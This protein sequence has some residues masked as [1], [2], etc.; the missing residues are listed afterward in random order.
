MGMRSELGEAPEVVRSLIEKQ[1]GVI[2]SV[3][4]AIHSRPVDMV[5]I[6]ARGTSD[7]AATYAQYVFGVYNKLPVALAAPSIQSLYGVVPRLHNALVIG[8]S[9]SGQSPDVVGVIEEARRQKA[10]TIAVTNDTGSPLSRAAEFHID[11]HAGP[12]L[13]VAATKTYVAELAALA[14]LSTALNDQALA[15]QQLGEVADAIAAAVGLE[16]A[17]ESAA[18]EQAGI[19]RAVVLG[20]GFNYSTAL[21]WSLK[22]KEMTYVL[23]DAYSTADFEHGPIAMI[24]P[25]FVVHAVAADG[26]T[27]PEIKMVLGRLRE[28][29]ARLVVASN[30]ADALAFA[31][32]PLRLPATPEWLS[33]LSAII[34][35]QLF[36]YHLALAKH[37]DTDHPRGIQKVTRTR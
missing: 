26:P 6:A 17:V 16:D 9:Q 13:A 33:P 37:L 2:D 1:R 20:R 28:A 35:G 31:D 7:H 5:L 36:A 11:I 30:S 18:R 34:P 10:P 8:I 19:R 27:L 24:D 25:G 29:G 4:E 14:M 3:A 23:A 22:L 12:E 15:R 32:V 21:E